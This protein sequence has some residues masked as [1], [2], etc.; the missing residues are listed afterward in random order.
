[1]R[2]NLAVFGTR[3]IVQQE[4]DRYLGHSAAD[5]ELEQRLAHLRRDDATWCVATLP[6]DNTEIQ[7]AFKMLDSR[8]A[9][10]LRA[11]NT[12]E[13]GTHYGRR[14]EFEY[15]AE[16]AP[17]QDAEAIERLVNQSA[18]ERNESRLL[19]AA[20]LTRAD[21]GVHGVLKLSRAQYDAWIQR[22]QT[23]AE[24]RASDEV[25]RR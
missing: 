22:V 2:S 25:S 7:D 18:S 24:L 9:D 17:N 12:L 14:V 1:L 19:P 5:P 15:R 8:L 4:L 20:E 3:G 21:N 10:L 6:R 11:G 23:S 13:I 16:L